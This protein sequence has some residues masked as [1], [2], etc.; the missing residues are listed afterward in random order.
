[1]AAK[2]TKLV[3]SSR[4]GNCPAVHTI[5]GHV[6]TARGEQLG[7]P[8]FVLVQGYRLADDD[9]RAQVRIDE[10]EDVWV[11]PVNVLLAAAD[12]IRA[13]ADG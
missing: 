7:G 11:M 12:K 8:D 10:G 3:E 6:A 1:M 9:A 13:G 2:I 5:D 4:S